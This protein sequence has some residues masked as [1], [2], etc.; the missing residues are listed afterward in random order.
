MF[1][2]YIIRIVGN[3][4]VEIIKVLT[5]F[6]MSPISFKIHFIVFAIYIVNLYPLKMYFVWTAVC[7]LFLKLAVMAWLVMCFVELLI[8]KCSLRFICQL[9]TALSVHKLKV[10]IVVLWDTGYVS[11]WSNH[12]QYTGYYIYYLFMNFL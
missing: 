1:I 11:S 3:I 10:N 4:I 6:R 2:E 12:I 9:W 7:N 8:V 5:C